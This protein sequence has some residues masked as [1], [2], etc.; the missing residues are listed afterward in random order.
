MYR[1]LRV[2]YCCFSVCFKDFCNE[3][4]QLYQ[5]IFNLQEYMFHMSLVKYVAKEG[6]NFGSAAL[7]YILFLVDWRKM[8]YLWA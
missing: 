5:K 6:P 1:V 7:A 8:P 4:K 2:I 3:K